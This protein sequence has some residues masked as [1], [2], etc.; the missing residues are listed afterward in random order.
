VTIKRLY[1]TIRIALMKNGYMR[2]AYLNKIHAFKSQG[3]HVNWQ[4]RYIPPESELIKI[5]NNVVI[6]SEVLF[7]NHDGI[8]YVLNNLNHEENAYK[9]HLGCIEIGDNVF[10]GSRT[11]ICPNVK[12]GSN[13]IIGAGSVVVKDIPG[14]II[15]GGNPAKEIGKFD[16][17]VY[18]RKFEAPEKR[19]KIDRF[20]DT[21]LKFYKKQK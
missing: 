5:G 18:T 9:I 20:D 15:A 19:K 16:K 6:A 8:H 1:H 14:G 7:I 21:W 12:I 10:I 11:I 4:P 17:L 13:V 2:A 3:N